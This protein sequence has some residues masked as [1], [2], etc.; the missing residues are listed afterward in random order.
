MTDNTSMHKKIYFVRH[1]Q[2]NS[3]DNKI[4]QSASS[5]LSA[6]G[7]LQSEEAAKKLKNLP[8][9]LILSSDFKRG[10]QTAE[11]INK[12]LN[13]EVIFTEYL[14]EAKRPTEIEG[15]PKLDPFVVD[16]RKQ[17]YD[18]FDDDWH[19]SDE[20]NYYDLKKRTENFFE[21]I[22]TRSEI[23][24]LAVTHYIILRTI[25]GFA[26]FGKNFNPQLLKRMIYYMRLDNT[27]ITVIE[28]RE[29]D[30]DWQLVTWNDY[31]HL[32]EEMRTYY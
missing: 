24:I 6:T 2:T 3:L 27:G 17:M 31:A 8:I 32:G 5:E 26:V 13:K 9:D 4:V 25:V 15:K 28:K 18:K 1:G 29:T 11:I 12:L 21:Y 23:N 22:S 20:D 10:I 7:I 16:V 30:D 14:R 19:Y